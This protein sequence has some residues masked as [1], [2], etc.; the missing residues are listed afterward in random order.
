M[1]DENRTTELMLLGEIKG[2][3]Q[4]LKDGQDQQAKRLDAVGSRLDGMDERLRK[5]ETK[6]AVFG[7]LSG[8]AMSIGMALIIEGLKG[9]VAKGP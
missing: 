3:V 2:L 1:G 5:V 6:S 7:A 8:G 4:G 9:W